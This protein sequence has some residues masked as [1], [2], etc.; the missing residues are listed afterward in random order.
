MSFL[1]KLVYRFTVL[2]RL[3]R[4][5]KLLPWADIYPY[6]S[7]VVC[8]PPTIFSDVDFMVYHTEEVGEVLVATGYT[9]S[10]WTNYF[11]STESFE[12]RAWRKGV[13]NVVTTANRT[14]YD[15]NAVATHICKRYNVLQKYHR[16]LIYEV[17]RNS[18]S[19]L[20]TMVPDDFPLEIKNLLEKFSGAYGLAIFE[21]YRA[22]YV[23]NG[24]ADD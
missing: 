5:K 7:R 6:G 14:L 24:D 12:F 1:Q 21:A 18:E 17:V 19:Q 13:I 2:P 20:L 16:V 15:R 10:H 22:K 11:G 23:L 8:N 9:E 3:K 4:L